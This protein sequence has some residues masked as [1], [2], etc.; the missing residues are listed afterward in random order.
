MYVQ[1]DPHEYEYQFNVKTTFLGKLG[2][3]WTKRRFQ[4]SKYDTVKSLYSNGGI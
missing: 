4:N 2:I 1:R 3:C